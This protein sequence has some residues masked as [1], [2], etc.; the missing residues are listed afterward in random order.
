[1]SNEKDYPEKYWHCCVKLVNSDDYA[2]ENDLL[3]SDLKRKIIDPWNEG[4][5]FTVKG[6]IIRKNESVGEIRVSQ[7]ENVQK[8]YAEQHNIQMR[9]SGIADM[10][11]N[12]KMLPFD[13]GKD[14]T[15]QLL[16]SGAQNA[17]P[18]PDIALIEQV[19]K[20][21]PNAAR[22]LSN[23]QSK[24][25]QPYDIEDEY[26]VQDLLH[27][28]L[29]AYVKYSVQEDPIPKVAG[30]KSSRA[31]ISIE[32]LSLLIEIKYAR[33]PNDQ[34][35]IFEEISQDLTLYTAW[36]PLKTLFVVIYNSGDLK[37]PEALEKLGG[38]KEISG[39]RF[40]VVVILS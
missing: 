7:T 27:G 30:S 31:D 37:D 17:P 21:L 39:K 33:G 29:R 20:R 23:R 35:R 2:I 12:R 3:F 40:N 18:E 11:T 19:C 38:E 26:D 13:E 22:I 28:I 1:M 32:E 15:F 4:R 16:F 34:K 25:K 24:N 6:A 9:A 10:A 8:V 5:P 14:Y 36:K